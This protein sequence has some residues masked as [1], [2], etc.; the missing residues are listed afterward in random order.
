M[1]TMNARCSVI[2]FG[3]TAAAV[4]LSGC[5]NPVSRMVQEDVL[6]EKAGGRP[7]IVSRVPAAGADGVL[8]DTTIEVEFNMALAA[9]ATEHLT[10]TTGGANPQTVEGALAYDDQTNKLT[11]VPSEPLEVQSR[12]TVSVS[13]ELRNRGGAPLGTNASWSF[14]TTPVNPDQFRFEIDTSRIDLDLS[15]YRFYISVQTESSVSDSFLG[16]EFFGGGFGTKHSFVVDASD[17]GASAGER[18]LVTLVVSQSEFVPVDPAENE[19]FSTGIADPAANTL[20]WL[21]YEGSTGNSYPQFS[22]LT[23]NSVYTDLTVS[24]GQ[25]SFPIG[26]DTS[27]SGFDNTLLADAFFDR[28]V[29]H[30]LTPEDAFLTLDYT[31]LQSLATNITPDSEQRVEVGERYAFSAL[32]FTSG[33]PGNHAFRYGSDTVNNRDSYSQFMLFERSGSR[34]VP[35]PVDGEPSVTTRYTPAFSPYDRAGQFGYL[36][37]QS[38]DNGPDDDIQDISLTTSTE[39]LLVADTWLHVP[40]TRTGQID[41]GAFRML[42]DS[43]PPPP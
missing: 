33:T 8:S 10:V 39:Y 25:G 40:A 41:S 11:F 31:D 37:W 21:A 20:V 12:Y 43:T 42:V 13:K 1:K 23:G 5:S 30:T 26:I 6:V 19:G 9:D 14:D 32:T 16:G 36:T 2:L 34:Y 4:I 3:L 18:L 27:L 22:N 7:A 38:G 28:G 29:V 17:V 24:Y 15:A 35:V